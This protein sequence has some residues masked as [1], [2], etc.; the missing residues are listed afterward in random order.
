MY[1]DL[2][3]VLHD[4]MFVK[5]CNKGAVYKGFLPTFALTFLQLFWGYR[6]ILADQHKTM[7]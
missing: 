4:A 2:D 7:Q 6:A 5:K 3:S 1:K